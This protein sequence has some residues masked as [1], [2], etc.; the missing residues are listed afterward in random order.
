MK[1]EDRIKVSVRPNLLGNSKKL[2]V[3]EANILFVQIIVCTLNCGAESVR[4]LHFSRIARA[5]A[6][7][8]ADFSQI[9]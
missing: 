7:A 8:H 1:G 5:C 6:L 3:S 4:G 9:F 2:T